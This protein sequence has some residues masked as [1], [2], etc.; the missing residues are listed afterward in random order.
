MAVSDARKSAN[1][2]GVR[3]VVA[4]FTQEL[5]NGKKVY[6]RQPFNLVRF[7]WGNGEYQTYM[8][9]VLGNR[10]KSYTGDTEER[11]DE[12]RIMDKADL[13]NLPNIE[14]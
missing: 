14:R 2:E 11:Y 7:H 13:N 6:L 4:V 3:E 5:R 12:V 1:K 8:E 10:F 9:L